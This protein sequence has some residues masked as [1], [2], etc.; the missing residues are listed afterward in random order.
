MI[1]SGESTGFA[2][3][4]E[5]YL[6]LSLLQART[7]TS[8]LRRMGDLS[9]DRLPE[10]SDRELGEHVKLSEKA[11][12]A[13]GELRREFD[14]E[15]VLGRLAQTGASAVTLADGG[16]PE[17]LREMP[18]PPP[19]LFVRGTIPEG[20]AV[21]LVGS[22]KASVTGIE[23]AR[24]LGRALG[25][26]GVCVVSGLALGIDAAA[27]EG[28]LASG[29]PTAGVLGCGI[30][31]IYPRRN[32]ELFERVRGSG[33][34]VSEYYLGEQPLPWR[35]PARN[36]VISGLS[37]TVVVVEASE[38]SGALIT[39]RHALE[40]G[41]DV[42]SVPGPLRPPECR[43]SN[44]LLGD[45]A[46]VIWDVAEFV[47][48]VAPEPARPVAPRALP[49]EE[50]EEGELPQHEARVLLEV[51]FE[52]TGVDVISGRSGVGMRELLPVLSMLELKGYVARDSGG[53][54][55]RR[56]R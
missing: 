34:V 14:A 7:G 32:R 4:R 52:A 1:S 5:G 49:M 53:S 37:E 41:Q 22:R 11:R 2:G 15:A 47:D 31:V 54:Y 55:S 26:R 16:Y 35:F 39:A 25:E 23:N 13:F 21:A 30:D 38:K 50:L 40:A 45:G 48:A 10:M 29:G 17:R 56:G 3:S 33:A 42:W 19:A 51:G 24:E 27:H 28:A 43:G 44:R 9:P 8:L 36:R 6:F 20:P 18:D 12:R 46:G